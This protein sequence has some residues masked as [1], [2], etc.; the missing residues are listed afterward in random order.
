MKCNKQIETFFIV[1]QI[2]RD[3]LLNNHCILF[4]IILYQ[5]PLIHL[6]IYKWI[7]KQMKENLKII[8]L[9]ILNRLQN[10][11]FWS[12]FIHIN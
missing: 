6:R 1:I 11:G 3:I 2:K 10:S 8:T 5:I 4:T 7:V 12:I 9:K